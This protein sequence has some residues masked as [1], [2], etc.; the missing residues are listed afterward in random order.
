M[1]APAKRNGERR[2]YVSSPQFAMHW[3]GS[4]A[5]VTEAVVENTSLSKAPLRSSG[6]RRGPP[7]VADQHALFTWQPY[8]SDSGYSSR[9]Y[10]YDY[11]ASTCGRAT[12]NRFGISMHG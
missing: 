11:A 2:V 9:R 8:R 5:S 3:W 7:P 4:V 10:R 12:P 6:A 1:K